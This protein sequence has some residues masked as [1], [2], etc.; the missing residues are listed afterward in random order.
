MYDDMLK[1]HEKVNIGLKSYVQKR[2]KITHRFDT[3]CKK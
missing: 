3:M 1:K 2:V